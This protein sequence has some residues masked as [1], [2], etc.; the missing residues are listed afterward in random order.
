VC[1]SSGEQHACEPFSLFRATDTAQTS[2]SYCLICRPTTYVHDMAIIAL[3]C[4]MGHMSHV[5]CYVK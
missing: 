5:C 2:I 3:Q 4:H 1:A